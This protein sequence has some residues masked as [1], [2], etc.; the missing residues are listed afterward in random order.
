MTD[1]KPTAGYLPRLNPDDTGR[2]CTGN[3]D[4]F[5]ARLRLTADTSNPGDRIGSK[6]TLADSDQDPQLRNTFCMMIV[7][8]APWN[9]SRTFRK[10]SVA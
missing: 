2:N 10:P 8:S 4:R 6:T 7:R 3:D 9:S 1:R 5:I